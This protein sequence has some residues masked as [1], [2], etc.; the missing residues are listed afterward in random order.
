MPVTVPVDYALKIPQGYGIID[1][2]RD[3]RGGL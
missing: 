2:K 3:E 1:I